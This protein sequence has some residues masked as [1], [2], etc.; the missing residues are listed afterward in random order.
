MDSDLKA[1]VKRDYATALAQFREGAERG[2]A[3][4]QHNLAL[5]YDKGNG[6]PQD[7]A[8]AMKWYLKAAE[9]GHADSQYNLGMMYLFGVGVPQDY[10]EAY[11]WVILANTKEKEHTKGALSA[12]ADKMSPE[13]IAGAQEA[14]QDWKEKHGK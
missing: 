6:V 8:E 14:A 12:I 2:D 7:Y 5:M 10:V 11:K 3:T 9:Q 1:Y 4:A 13:Q